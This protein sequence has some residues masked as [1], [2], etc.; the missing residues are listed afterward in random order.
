MVAL[1]GAD[2]TAVLVLRRDDGGGDMEIGIEC[3]L[4]NFGWKK[5][6]GT[7]VMQQGC[8]SSFFARGYATPDARN[9]K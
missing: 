9:E 4:R 3:E 7:H 2:Q 5:E 1:T 8:V 6:G